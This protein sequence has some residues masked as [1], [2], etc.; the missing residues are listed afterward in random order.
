MPLQ[1]ISLLDELNLAGPPSRSGTSR[2]PPMIAPTVRPTP[3]VVASS[4]S[5]Q[6][7]DKRPAESPQD[8]QLPLQRRRIGD[9]SSSQLVTN[10]PPLVQPWAPTLT[11]LDGT[12]LT[13]IDKVKSVDV[14]YGV[15]RAA[16]LPLDMEREKNNSYNILMKSIFQSSARV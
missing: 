6:Q 5:H 8:L 12:P 16:L 4:L 13:M 7:R 10:S 2:A 14:A 9:S 1:P 11:W 15:A 3:T